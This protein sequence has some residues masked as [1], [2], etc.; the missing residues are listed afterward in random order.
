MFERFSETARRS[1]FFARYEASAMASGYIETEHLLL[2]LLREDHGLRRRLSTAAMESIRRKVEQRYPG[3]GKEISTSVDMPVSHQVKRALGYAAEEAEKLGHK[4]IDCGHLVLGLLRVEECAAAGILRE[5]G[6]TD[7]GQ[8]KFLRARGVDAG[9]SFEPGEREGKEGGDEEER[10]EPNPTSASLAADRLKGLVEHAERYLDRYSGQDHPGYV[11]LHGRTR[12][13]ALGHLID[14]AAA[15]QQWFARALT[16]PKLVAAGYPQAE[17]VAAQQ[18]ESVQWTALVSLWA[19]ANLML[20]HVLRHVPEEK[21]N[22]PCRI[23]IAAA[24]S[25]STLIDRYV[26]HCEDGI[27]EILTLG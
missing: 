22:T 20:A 26:K 24:I 16:E 19:S 5:H 11:K 25:L 3:G 15:H 1:V 4:V 10:N 21:L 2:G 7:E 17:W 8:R 12:R 14:W 9:F 6:I 13:A 27:G 18:Y 23:G